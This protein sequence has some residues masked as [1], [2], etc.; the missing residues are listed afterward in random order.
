MQTHS[1]SSPWRRLL[2]MLFAAWALAG[3]TQEKPKWDVNNPPG[4]WNFKEVKFTTDEG[5][6][7]NLDVSPD[8]KDIVFDLLGDIYSMP[9]TGGEARLLRSGLAYEVQ[10]RYSPDG[11]WISF[12]SDAGGGDNIWVMRN[13]GTDARQITKEDF[14]LLNNAV[15]APDGHYLIAR[16]HFTSGRS[17][18]AGEMW[19]YHITGGT[20]IQLT[21]RKNDQ[22]DVNEPTVSPDGRYLYFSED[23][24]P[25]GF[26]QYNKDPNS[27]IYVIKRYDREKGE[28]KTITGGPGSAS[29]PQISR[30]GNLLAFLKRVRTQ[31]VLFIHD[32]RTGEEWP[33][34]DQLHKDQ[35]EAWAIFGT[36][37]GFNWTPDDT[38]IIVWAKGKIRKI[39][40]ATSKEEIIPFRANVEVKIAEA[41]RSE[42]KAFEDEVELKAIRHATTSPDGKLMVF[43]AAGYLWK[44]TLPNGKPERLT[45]GTDLEFEPSFSPSGE[46]L[47]FVTWNDET[48]GAIVRWNLKAKKPALVKT[49]TERGIYRNPSYAPDGRTL[50]YVKESGNE[51]QG[52]A[53]GKDPGIYT[54]PL[55]GGKPSFVTAEGDFPQ[56]SLDGKRIYYQTGGYF[57]GAL[58]KSLKSVNL[59][60]G[61]ERTHV[62]SKYANR[63]VMSPDQKW[64]AFTLLHKAYVAAMPQVGQVLDLDAKS[65]HVPVAALSRDAGINLHWSADSR[66]IHWTLGN[67]YF[68]NELKERFAFLEGAPEKIGPVDSVGILIGLKLPADK[69]TGTLA[70]KGARIIT[71]EG[72]QVIEKGTLLIRDNRIVAIGKE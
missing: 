21:K 13:D 53:F 52:Y 38:H 54:I 8:G 24:Y 59:T 7:M 1:T 31:S 15:W 25:G 18:G 39:E 22:Q 6:W 33:V 14:R 45:A 41:L 20:G 67:R 44:K 64:V 30:S 34:Y 68:S 40:V 37:T 69:P 66:R 72:N 61:D 19:M 60:G 29:R 58:T 51:H 46:E 32:L 36:Y 47:V 35:Q 4:E 65:S 63:M 12:T 56:V 23:M 43:N 5:T 62:Q 50:V 10:P 28:V 70:L 27:Q 3:Y 55:S 48:G 11:K 71:M 57:F 16:K 9:V 26:F 49:T 17:L 42:Q 2:T